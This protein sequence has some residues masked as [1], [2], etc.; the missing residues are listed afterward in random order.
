VD[1]SRISQIVDLSR[2][3]Q[4]VFE[5]KYWWTWFMGRIPQWSMV[6]GGPVTMAGREAHRSSANG[7]SGHWDVAMMAQGVAG[8]YIEAF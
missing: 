5:L 3:S 7:C 2:I 8:E 1:L 6:H 4:I